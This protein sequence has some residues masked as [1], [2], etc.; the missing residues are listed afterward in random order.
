LKLASAL[1]ELAVSVAH[2]FEPSPELFHTFR[3]KTHNLEMH[4]ADAMHKFFCFVIF[5]SAVP[6]FNI[7]SRFAGSFKIEAS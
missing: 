2:I 7:L 3:S 1:L 6:D 4:V 5:N